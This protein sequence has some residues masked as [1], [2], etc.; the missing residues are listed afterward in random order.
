[1]DLLSEIKNNKIIA[2]IRGFNCEEVLHIA[3][4]LN[5][6]GLPFMEI[7]FGSGDSDHV[8]ASIIHS[9]RRR[10]PKLHIGAGTVLTV[11]QVNAA[12]NAGA[13]YIISPNTNFPVIK[14]TKRLGMLSIPGALSP[15]EVVYA[16]ESGAD[17][18]KVF[19]ADLLGTP[20][21]RSLRSPLP[22]IP[23]AAVGGINLDNIRDFLKTGIYFAGI[24]SNII[25]SESVRQKHYKE[26]EDCAKLYLHR[27]KQ[28]VKDSI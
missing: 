10:F 1:M 5:D 3:E 26:I 21:I 24:G 17:I 27:V 15:S 25:N 20:Y 14:E 6:A 9:L 28:S 18:I 4:A 7:T 16:Y 8:T 19:P 23:L 11:S 22:H 12:Y 2:I 13:E